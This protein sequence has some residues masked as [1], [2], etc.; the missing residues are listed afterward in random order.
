MDTFGWRL[1]GEVSAIAESCWPAGQDRAAVI[2]SLSSRGAQPRS[3]PESLGQV[4]NQIVAVHFLQAEDIRGELGVEIAK[5]LEHLR[6]GLHAF[7]APP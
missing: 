6:H 4:F 2:L 3:H 5:R 7:A 1:T